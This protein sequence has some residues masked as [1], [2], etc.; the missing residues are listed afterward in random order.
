MSALEQIEVVLP[1]VDVRRKTVV[2]EEEKAGVH[3]KAAP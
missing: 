3:A 1:K 2:E